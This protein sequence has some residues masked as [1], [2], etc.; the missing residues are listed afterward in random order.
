MHANRL[1]KLCRFARMERSIG[2]V[3]LPE[4]LVPYGAPAALPSAG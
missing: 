1:T 2:S 3:Q 4:V